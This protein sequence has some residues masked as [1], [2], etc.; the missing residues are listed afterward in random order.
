MLCP[1]VSDQLACGV[2]EG[3]RALLLL[4]STGSGIRLLRLDLARLVERGSMDWM[5]AQVIN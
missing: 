2:T 4:H 1:Q 5:V 3:G